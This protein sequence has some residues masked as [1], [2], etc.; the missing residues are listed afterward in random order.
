VVTSD[1]Q[2][3][4]AAEDHGVRVVSSHTFARQLLAL[5]QPAATPVEPREVRL[6]EA[7]IAEWLRLF[8]EAPEK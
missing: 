6:S 1:R 5:S 7:E 4:R 2:V 8:G 3:A